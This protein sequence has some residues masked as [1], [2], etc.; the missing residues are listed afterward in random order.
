MFKL[1]KI[2]D[3][4]PLKNN[5]RTISKEDFNILCLS[6]SNNPEFFNARPCIL[7]D[8]T[9]ELVII[10]GNNRYRAAKQIGLTKVPTYLIS[11]LSE[12]GE[13]EIIIRDNINNGDFN[14]DILANEFDIADL[15]DWGMDL[16]KEFALENLDEEEYEVKQK[17]PTK[18][19][20]T[21]ACDLKTNFDKI[22]QELDRLKIGYTESEK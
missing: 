5:P 13:K 14:F 21:I 3:I 20:L 17:V 10:G 2:A 7:S 11:G 6:I 22:K 15:L 19:I 9:G 1:R 8:R 16:P 18:F 12:S 4:F